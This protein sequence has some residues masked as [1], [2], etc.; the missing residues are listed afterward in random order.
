MIHDID[1]ILNL[2]GSEIK[3]VHAA[4][5]SVSVCGEMGGNPRNTP[6]LVGLGVDEISASPTYLPEVKRVIRALQFSEAKALA[7]EALRSPSCESIKAMLDQWLDEHGCGLLHA[8]KSE[9]PEN[10]PASEVPDPV[11]VRRD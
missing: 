10:T 6:I 8:L 3:D 9:E 7:D 1:L 2:V 11:E 5:I 4:G